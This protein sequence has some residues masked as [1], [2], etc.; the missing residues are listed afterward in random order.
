MALHQTYQICHAYDLLDRVFYVSAASNPVPAAVYC[1]FYA[2]QTFDESVIVLN[3]GV[4]L[5]LTTFYGCFP[6][7]PSPDAIKIDM[8]NECEGW[9][10]R[11]LLRDASLQREQL[12]SLLKDHI[13]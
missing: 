4:A 10:G 3:E 1:Q 6:S 11:D 12:R 13:V 2:E 7:D 9:S 8:Y 5:A